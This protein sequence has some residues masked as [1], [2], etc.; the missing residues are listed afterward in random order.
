[1]ET[2]SIPLVSIGI[3]TYNG[4]KRILK[5]LLSIL[6]QD[7]TNLE[8]LI[9]DNG[10]VDNTKEVV[11]ELCKIYPQI[12]YYRQATNL[13][14]MPNFNFL[15]QNASGIYFMWVSDD[16]E[17]EPGVVPKYVDFLENNLNYSLASGKIKYWKNGT[18]DILEDGFNFEQN[19]PSQR[20]ISF[21][22]KVIY[23]GM[24]HGLMRREPI[25]NVPIR[26]IIGND[27]HFVANL[28]YLGK[29]RNFD[30][31]GYHKNFGGLSSSFVQYA[32]A[33]GESKFAGRF[34]HLKMAG[35]A[36]SEVM[37]RSDY[38]FDQATTF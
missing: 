37:Y 3:P 14:M 7:Y 11:E 6:K 26:S 4:S 30:F 17:L 38:F 13:G 34:P 20:V 27:Y 25:K 24:L 15:L 36:F 5:P 35:D 28:A 18:P 21:Y 31:V 16:D 2:K 22:F 33:I 32:K 19:S 12:K 8:I 1:M 29:I 10:S 9:S 23:C